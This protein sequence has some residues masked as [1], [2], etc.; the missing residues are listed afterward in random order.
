MAGKTVWE[1]IWAAGRPR[2]VA[3]RRRAVAADGGEAGDRWD[4]RRDYGAGQDPPFYPRPR[5]T[6]RRFGQGK[7]QPPVAKHIY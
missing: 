2:A 3:A 6:A 5:R 7:V 4:G 1:T